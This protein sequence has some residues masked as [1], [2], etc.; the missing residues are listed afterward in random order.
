M[1]RLIALGMVLFLFSSG[2]CVAAGSNAEDPVQISLDNLKELWM[3]HSPDYAKLKGDLFIA[4]DSLRDVSDA[5]DRADASNNVSL[6]NALFN[7]RD[8]AKLAY[9]VAAA[10][11]NAKIENAVLWVKQTFFLCWQDQLNLTFASEKLAQ[12]REQLNKN[13]NGVQTGYLSQKAYQ[14]LKNSVDDLQNTVQTLRNKLNIDETTLKSKLGLPL[15]ATLQYTYPELNQEFFETRMKLD[16]SADLKTMQA[17]SVTLKV[18]L[19]TR[20]SLE[21]YKRS[22]A[23]SNQVASAQLSLDTAK[24]T[25][26]STYTAQY[27]RLMQQYQDLQNEYRRLDV[28][29]DRISKLQ[30]QLEKG[31]ISPLAFSNAKLDYACLETAVKVK[32]CSLYDTYLSYTNMVAGN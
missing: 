18:L 25:L 16:P 15:N 3:K 29:K 27:Q 4:S 19:L 30:K 12:K 1:K 7:S 28:E 5:M 20:D 10:Q 8:Q 9:D 24:A 21:I 22:Y 14:D 6:L 23:N 17:N 26:P 13:G 32:A 31:Y 11:K 2:L